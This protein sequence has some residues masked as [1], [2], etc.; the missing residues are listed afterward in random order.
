MNTRSRSGITHNT[1]VNLCFRL[2]IGNDHAGFELET[3]RL[4]SYAGLVRTY[5]KK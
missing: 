2:S 5:D 4:K 3:Q 1:T